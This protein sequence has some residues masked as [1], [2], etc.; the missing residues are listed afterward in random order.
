[1]SPVGPAVLFCPADRPDRYVK[2]AVAADAV[3]FDLE[4]GVGPAR[5][6][7]ARKALADAFDEL[8]PARTFVRINPPDTEE[9]RADLDVLRGGPLRAVM[10]PKAADPDAIAALAPFEVVALC[11]TA[12]GVL[13][14]SDLAAVENCTALMWGG[15]DLIADIGGQRSRRT[16]GS[17]LP[18]VVH[19]RSAVLLAAAANRKAAWDGVYLAIEDHAGLAAECEEAVAMGFAAKV[20]IHPSH[21]PI[22]RSAYV[23]DG[24]RVNWARELLEASATAGDGVFRFRGQM[25]D[26]PLIAQA[27]AI[28]ASER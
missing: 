2:A 21:V 27:R 1:M 23:A 10:L 13:A 20:A 18:V 15:E 19:A 3:I 4:D 6:A 25:V 26:G 12:G 7:A 17:Y 22:I 24:D 5:K 11:G 8:D 28:V 14:A 16:D 9:G